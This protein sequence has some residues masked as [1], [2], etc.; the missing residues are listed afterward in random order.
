MLQPDVTNIFEAKYNFF[1]LLSSQPNQ[2]V[3]IYLY[4]S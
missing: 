2:N 1:F 4:Q 3:I